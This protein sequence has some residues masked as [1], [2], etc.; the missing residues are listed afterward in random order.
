MYVRV[1]VPKSW[2]NRPCAVDRAVAADSNRDHALRAGPRHPTGT[3]AAAHAALQRPR[4][5]RRAW[6][7]DSLPADFLR[8]RLSNC[9]AWK[10]LV[11]GLQIFF[12]ELDRVHADFVRQLVHQRFGRERRLRKTRRPHRHADESSLVWIGACIAVNVLGVVL[13]RLRGDVRFARCRQ[14]RTSG[15]SSRP[16]ACRLWSTPAFNFWIDP[17]PLPAVKNSSVPGQHHL[18]RPTFNC[19]RQFTRPTGPA[20]PMPNLDP[21]P[22]PMFWTMP[23]TA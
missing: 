11:F 5:R 6:G 10:R 1:P 19:L 9:R 4:R 18:D 14:G 3:N 23:V 20:I 12:A 13:V 15:R 16:P 17:G 22:P 21:K 7:C 8:P 2:L